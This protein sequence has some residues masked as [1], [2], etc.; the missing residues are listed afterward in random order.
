MEILKRTFVREEA[1]LLLKDWIVKGKLQPNQKLRDKEL[2]EQL[3]VSRT[4]IREALLRLEEEGLVETKPNSATLVSPIDF[5]N[6]PNLYSIVWTLEGLAVKQ[7]FELMTEK[8]LD[9]MIEANERLFRALTV[10]NPI[11]AIEADNDF[12]SIYIQLSKNQDLS[13]MISLAKQKINR[14]KLF[15]FN[16]V[17]ETLSSYNEH[18]TIIK[19]IQE[20]NL[21]LALDAVESNWMASCLRIQTKEPLAKFRVRR[22]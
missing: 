3:G 9:Q 22:F 1:Y 4:P 13:Q 14:L 7:S 10:G 18:L 21:L 5:H 17:K 19:A 2:A 8:H 12:H 16:E 15:Y 6:A 20:K 11:L